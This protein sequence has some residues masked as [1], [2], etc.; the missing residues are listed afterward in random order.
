[1]KKLLILIFLGLFVMPGLASARSLEV[2]GWIPYWAT[3]GGIESA[4]D[5]IDKLDTIYPF[6]YEVDILG[7]LVERSDLSNNDWEDLFELTEDEDIEIIPTITWTKGLEIHVHLANDKWRKN[8]IER[9]VK[10]VEEGD[11]DGVNI[12]YESKLYLTIGYFSKFLEELKDEL[13]DKI[14]TCAI[15]ARTPPADLYK[16]VPTDIKYANDYKEIAKHCDRVEIMAYDQQRADLSLNDKKKGVPYVPVADSDWVEKVVKLAIKDIP[17]DKIMLGI[18]TYGRAWD[19]TVGPNWYKSYNSVAALNLPRLEVLA[20][21][22]DKKPGRNKAGE[23]SFS[24]FPEDSIFKI[25]DSLP[26]PEGTPEGMESAAK[27]L[28][29]STQTGMEVP[30][31]VAWYSD[32]GAIEDKVDLAKKYNLRGVALFKIDGEEDEDLWDLF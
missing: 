18:P 15:E 2:A 21:K 10:M 3:K 28:L 6:V 11:F 7:K 14:L 23:L 17:A 32:A 8:H 1:M 20:D 19:V 27:A 30:V 5:N 26:A 4:E 29:F 9:I 16:N 24:Y 12:D 22:Y 25:L 13:D 31:R